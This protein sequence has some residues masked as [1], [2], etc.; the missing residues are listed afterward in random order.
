MTTTARNTRPE[1]GEVLLRTA[2]AAER[3]GVSQRT[4]LAWAQKGWL[5]SLLTPGG[6]RRYRAS[7][8]ERHAASGPLLTPAEVAARFRVSPQSVSRWLAAGRLA[9]YETAGGHRRAYAAD[10]EA[11][12][13]W[14]G[15]GRYAAEEPTP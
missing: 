10:V 1:D 7:D 11:L 4:V 2:E 9:G 12:L 13:A 8:V 15:D 3:I 5:P 14:D 6:H